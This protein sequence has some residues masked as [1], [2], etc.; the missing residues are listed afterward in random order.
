MIQLLGH[1]I[2]LK[3]VLL[4]SQTDILGHFLH[5]YFFA[6]L[7]L[8]IWS[9]EWCI[10]T[11]RSFVGCMIVMTFIIYILTVTNACNDTT[12]VLVEIKYWWMLFGEESSCTNLHYFNIFCPLT[13][14][15]ID[16]TDRLLRQAYQDWLPNTLDRINA[17]GQFRDM[18]LK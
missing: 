8:L 16:E 9:P 15:V 7:Y 12:I 14:Q 3:V 17:K 1:W 13:C 4:E 5:F 10:S 11:T 2:S 6:L 18:F